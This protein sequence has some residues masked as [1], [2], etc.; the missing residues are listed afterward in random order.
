MERPETSRLKKEKNEKNFV[1]CAYLHKRGRKRERRSPLNDASIC[2]GANSS[3][4]VFFFD[5][6]EA[7]RERRYAEFESL[8][9][10]ENLS[11]IKP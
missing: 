3:L 7:R 8:Y 11:R 6:G 1:F 10:F 5:E 2:F 9:S 4:A